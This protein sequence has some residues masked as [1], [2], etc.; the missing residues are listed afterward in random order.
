MNNYT[1]TVTY[2]DSNATLVVHTVKA[3]NYN[4]VYEKI[5]KLENGDHFTIKSIN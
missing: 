3:N 4:E 5:S 1:Y 2:V